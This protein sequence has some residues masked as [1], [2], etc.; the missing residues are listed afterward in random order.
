MEN[1]L[2]SIIMP[3]KNTEQYVKECVDSIL[4]QYYV[5]WELLVVDDN[6]TDNTLPILKTYAR[7]DSRIKVY[8]NNGNG[9]IDALRLA[10]SKSNGDLITRMDADDVMD[11][12]KL[13]VLSQNLLNS[14]KGHI[15]VGLVKYFSEDELGEGFKN[16]E[17]WL[18]SLTLEGRNFEEIYKEC[19]IPSPCWMIFK[20]DLEKCDAFRPN[21]YPEDYDLTFR[22]Y[23]NGLQPISCNKVLHY[24]R[25]YA[26]RTSRTNEHYA[27]NTFLAIKSHYFLQL[28]R[29]TDKNLVIWGAGGKGK[30]LAQKLIDKNI[31][32]YWICDNP[33]KIGKHIYG[34]QLLAFN[35]LDNIENSQSIVTVANPKAQE[36]IKLFFNNRGK[37]AMIDYFFFC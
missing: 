27:D 24:W 37:E 23:L 30:T 15:A 19:V 29:A 2:V 5:N 25:D 8:Q 28:E 14:G 9:I 12:E 21:Q 3:I 6:S 26:S 16:Y 7:I 11:K 1:P 34:Q 17:N 10:Y 33:K 13:T 4:A 31:A 32:F 35:E 36:E 20:E 18:N 22:F